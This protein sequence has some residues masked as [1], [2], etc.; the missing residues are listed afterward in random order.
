MIHKK[1]KHRRSHLKMLTKLSAVA[2]SAAPWQEGPE[3][4]FGGTEQVTAE[5][6]ENPEKH[7]QGGEEM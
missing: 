5:G 3:S 7:R 2:T 6:L 1:D 4:S